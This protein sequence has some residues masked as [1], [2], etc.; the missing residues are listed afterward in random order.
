MKIDG[1]MPVNV[2][3]LYNDNKKVKEKA[4]TVAKNDTVEISKEARNLS[5]LSAENSWEVSP[6]RVEEVKAQISAGN[7]NVSAKRLSEKM[8]DTIKGRGI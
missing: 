2:S 4:I 8:M 7:Y 5:S 1:T 6:K 3:K